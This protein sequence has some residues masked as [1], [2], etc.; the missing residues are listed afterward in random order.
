MSDPRDGPFAQAAAFA[1]AGLLQAALLAHLLATEVPARVVPL[2]H[3]LAVAAAILC[4]VAVEV[5]LAVWLNAALEATV[6]RRPRGPWLDLVKAAGLAC[7]LGLSAA[8][9]A[10]LGVYLV[11]SG[12]MGW[13]AA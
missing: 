6:G 13:R 8:V 3:R 9:L 4:L 7:L 11:V 5:A 1:V 2:T 10:A 12:L